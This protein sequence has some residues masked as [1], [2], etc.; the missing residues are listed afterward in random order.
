MRILVTG[1]TGFVGKNLKESLF[2]GFNMAGRNIGMM[3]MLGSNPQKNFLKIWALV[4]QSYQ[5]SKDHS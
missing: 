2:D 4:K 1:G 5:R 3:S